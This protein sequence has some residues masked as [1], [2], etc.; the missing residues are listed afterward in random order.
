MRGQADTV[1]ELL[2]P[3]AERRVS[4]GEAQGLEGAYDP[5]FAELRLWRLRMPDGFDVITPF[6]YHGAGLPTDVDVSLGA[7]VRAAAACGFQVTILHPPLSP[8]WWIADIRPL[9]GIGE[10]PVEAVLTKVSELGYG[11]T[12]E[13]AVARAFVAAV[14]GAGLGEREGGLA[15]PPL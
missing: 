4:Q 13:E 5:R 12:P 7:I 10:D 1:A 11:A 3:L 6:P 14:E 8:D 15:R 9:L 2:R